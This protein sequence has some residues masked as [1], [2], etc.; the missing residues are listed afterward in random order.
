MGT[1]SNTPMPEATPITPN[2][3]QIQSDVIP[4]AHPPDRQS[5]S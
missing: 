4:Q 3:I 2:G 5:D 1:P